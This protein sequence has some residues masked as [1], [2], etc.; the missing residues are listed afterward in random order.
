M[1]CWACLCLLNPARRC[2]WLSSAGYWWALA[3]EWAE[4]APAVMA[5]V[6]LGDNLCGQL[7]LPLPSWSQVC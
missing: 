6:A 1:P 4:A 3:R 2:R 7:S 5:Y